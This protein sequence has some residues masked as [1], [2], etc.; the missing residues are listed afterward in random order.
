MIKEI[1]PFLIEEFKKLK[2]GVEFEEP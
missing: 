1:I 2:S